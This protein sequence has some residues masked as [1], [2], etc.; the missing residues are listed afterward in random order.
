MESV[1]SNNRKEQSNNFLISGSK[2]MPDMH[3]KQ[4][5]YM[6][7]AWQPFQKKNKRLQEFKLKGYPR[8]INGN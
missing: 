4:S 1:L 8:Y 3:L 2:F 7:P 5:R 6:Y